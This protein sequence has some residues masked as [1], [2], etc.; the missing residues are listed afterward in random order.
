MK[1]DFKQNVISSQAQ[2]AASVKPPSSPVR[3]LNI[4]SADKSNTSLG[5]E[6]VAQEVPQKQQTS[7][8]SKQTKDSKGYQCTYE[9][10]LV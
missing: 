2:N 5:K 6:V 7:L 9:I 1:I 3:N 10:Y 4:L 8:K